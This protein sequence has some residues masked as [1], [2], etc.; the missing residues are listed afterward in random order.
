MTA[1]PGRRAFPEGFVWGTATASYQIEGA[2]AEDGRGPSIWDTFSHTPG[3]TLNGDTGDVACDHYHRWE[4]DL[5]LVAEIGLASY[6]FSVAWPRVRRAAPAGS[7]RR[8]SDFYDR[9]VDG[10][11]ARGID[12]MLTLYHWDLPQWLEDDGGWLSRDTAWRF[13]EYAGVVAGRLG[14][15]VRHFTTFNE[16]YCT[17]LLGY[18]SGVHAP[19][20]RGIETAL[21]AAHHLNLAHG[22]GVVAL[23]AHAARDIDVSVVLNVGQVYPASDDPADVLA[24]RHVDDLSNRIFLEPMLRGRYPETLLEEMS[25]TPTGASCATATSP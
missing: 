16:P 1:G 11:L 25:G 2:V 6:R 9:L 22:L 7:T 14:D 3:R 20:V 8:A 18:G 15:R 13:A 21:T 12:P 5:D 19:G 10:L 17:A 24:A 4:Q 23:R